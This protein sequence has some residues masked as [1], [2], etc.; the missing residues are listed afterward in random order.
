MLVVADA[1][2][3]WMKTFPIRN[4]TS[5]TKL[6]LLVYNLFC[7]SGVPKVIDSDNGS[8]FGGSII[9]EVCTL[10]NIHQKFHV[11]YHLALAEQVERMNRTIKTKLKKGVK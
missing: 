4:M 10:L 6:I 8:G 1:F 9:K 2:S 7:K 11:P 3:H 5:L